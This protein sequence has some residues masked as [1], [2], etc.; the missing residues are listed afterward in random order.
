MI[1]PKI[2]PLRRWRFEHMITLDQLARGCRS[3]KGYLSQLENYTRRPSVYMATRLARTTQVLGGK[4]T[5]LSFMSILLG[6]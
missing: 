3:S 4:A 5:S 1:G 2:H 6:E